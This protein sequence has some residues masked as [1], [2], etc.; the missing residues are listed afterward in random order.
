MDYSP[1][2]MLM[3]VHQ[4]LEELRAEAAAHAL[5]PPRPS[6][7]LRVALGWLRAQ[8]ATVRARFGR[9]RRTPD[10]PVTAPRPAGAR[11]LP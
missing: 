3:V 6:G 2:I 1:E 7:M 5:V 10:K 11:P 8:G 9:A 4:H